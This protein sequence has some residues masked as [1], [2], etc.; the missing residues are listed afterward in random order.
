MPEPVIQLPPDYRN[1]HPFDVLKEL[2]QQEMWL[3]SIRKHGVHSPAEEGERVYL[4]PNFGNNHE[5]SLCNAAVAIMER[6]LGGH[7]DKFDPYQIAVFYAPDNEIKSV[8]GGLVY[9]SEGGHFL[10]ENDEPYDPW[11]VVNFKFPTITH[12]IGL[13]V[14]N[15]RPKPPLSVC[16]PF[17]WQ[18]IDETQ[19]ERLLFSM[20]E[21]DVSFENV[22]WLQHTNSPDAGRDIS[23]ERAENGSRVLIQAKHIGATVTDFDLNNLVTRAETWDPPFDEV[24][25]STT[26]TFTQ[27]AIRWKE[28]TN[29]RKK[30]LLVG[31][32]PHSRLEIK[33]ARRPHLIAHLGLRL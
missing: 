6:D 12:N 16:T 33:L 22:E 7:A 24:I 5:L 8:C 3:Q 21:D 31:L 32:E 14:P 13:P 29:K 1:E 4:S 2:N 25:F 28:Q 10:D 26:S 23:A 30:R 27:N 11:G 18:Q 15:L 9:V 19:F 17:D 20:Y